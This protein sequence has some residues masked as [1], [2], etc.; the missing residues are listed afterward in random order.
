M[1]RLEFPCEFES[2]WGKKRKIINKLINNFIDGE[3]H[4]SCGAGEGLLSE[5]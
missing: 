2:K 5:E 3:G 4:S 1:K